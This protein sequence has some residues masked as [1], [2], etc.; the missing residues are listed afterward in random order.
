MK[1]GG[2]MKKLNKII[3]LITMISGIFVII[4]IFYSTVDKI[5]DD[6]KLN[7]YVGKDSG[8]RFAYIERGDKMK[9]VFVIARNTFLKYLA[10]AVFGAAAALKGVLKANEK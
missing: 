1:E 6:G 7:V 3:K 8:E 5:R 10:A 9:A 2:S 4:G